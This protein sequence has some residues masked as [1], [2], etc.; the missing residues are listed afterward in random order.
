MSA[1]KDWG[2][3]VAVGASLA[4]GVGVG[5]FNPA[6]GF[7][8]AEAS[9]MATGLVNN[10]LSTDE[11]L[12]RQTKKDAIS[13]IEGSRDTLENNLAAIQNTLVESKQLSTT[14]GD[15]EY[16]IG[17]NQD[18]LSMYQAMLNGEDNL[19]TQ[20]KTGLES[21]I[22]DARNAL[23]LAAQNLVSQQDQ[24]ALYIKSSALEV[25]NAK[26]TAYSS[27]AEMM[28]QK[29]LANVMAGA[30]G[31]VQSA[32]TAAAVQQNNEIQRLV[33]SDMKFNEDGSEEASAGSFA[34]EFSV[35]QSSINIQKLANETN[36]L[37]AQYSLLSSES[38]VQK[39]QTNLNLQMDSWETTFNEK[40]EENRG[41]TE[42]NKIDQE[43]V[44]GYTA[45][46]NT[47]QANAMAALND[48]KSNYK[49]AGVSKSEADQYI[50]DR[51]NDYINT[52]YSIG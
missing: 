6:L 28:K 34:R 35:L 47:L 9:L 5:I 15:R 21:D 45:L 17:V 30:S 8:V 29:S 41:W 48:Y 33:G 19:L 2:R 24:A 39:T 7:V 52:G 23:D 44:E 38:N 12:D 3:Y 25:K 40:T 1:W 42:A 26:D 11:A 50:N 16:N 27:Y 31:G 36:V 13:A 14:I 43:T 49:D 51:K 20:Q 32:Y 4:L 10:S 22:T 18:W 37:A 46:L